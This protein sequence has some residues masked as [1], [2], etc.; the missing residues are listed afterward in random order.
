MQICC[1]CLGILDLVIFDSAAGLVWCIRLFLMVVWLAMMGR[2]V[3]LSCCWVL[4]KQWLLSYSYILVSL[5]SLSPPKWRDRVWVTWVRALGLSRENRN[6]HPR[7]EGHKSPSVPQV[8]GH[9]ETHSTAL[10]CCLL[11]SSY[12]FLRKA[13][14]G[15]GWVCLCKWGMMLALRSALIDQI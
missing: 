11:G 14:K 15:Y 9:V 13:T 5:G 1:L 8:L 3:G 2:A 10:L 7:C 12:F 6:Q 4:K